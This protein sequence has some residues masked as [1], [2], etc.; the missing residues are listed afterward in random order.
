VRP[1]A[2]VLLSL[3][4]NGNVEARLTSKNDVSAILNR[5]N[6]L[7]IAYLL[8]L[9]QQRLLTI[10]DLTINDAIV[11]LPN[12]GTVKI[13]LGLLDFLEEDRIEILAASGSDLSVRVKGLN[14]NLSGPGHLLT[15]ALVE[16]FHGLSYEEV[17]V[18][19]RVVVDIGGFIGDTAAYFA[20]RGAKA[21]YVYEPSLEFVS[22]AKRNVSQ[23]SSIF[24]Y[25]YGL[26]CESRTDYLRGEGSSKSAGHS[27]GERAEIRN[28]TETLRDILAREPE[29]GLLKVDCE[30]CEW[31]LVKC[32]GKTI[33]DHVATVCVE[34][35]G[36]DHSV[37][38]SKLRTMGFVVEKMKKS[39]TPRVSMYL[40]A[41]S[42]SR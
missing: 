21:V 7:R 40:L 23:Y 33:F 32:L 30:G 29:I 11:S 6:T 25:E 5:K 36:G 24:L 28:A 16:M 34:V 42:Q 37:F 1:K 3:A 15:S 35:H 31:E 9:E 41:R 17:D 39:G 8:S 10:Q 14:F 13:P 4:R 22:V 2:K 12:H 27:T 38:L 20:S 26:G 18:T 19:G